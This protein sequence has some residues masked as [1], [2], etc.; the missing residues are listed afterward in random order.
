MLTPSSWGDPVANEPLDRVMSELRQFVR[1]REWEQFHDPKNLAMAVVSEAGELAA[2]YRWIANE[3]AD[4][5]SRNPDN[6]GRVA[7][8]AADVGVALLLFFD[9]LGVDFLDAVRSKIEVNR[10]N[11]P[12]DLSKGRSE[13]PRIPGKPRQ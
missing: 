3:Q 4:V 2:E 8:E 6:R 10:L 9:R 12:P 5:W 7:A 1:E 11:Y 13:R